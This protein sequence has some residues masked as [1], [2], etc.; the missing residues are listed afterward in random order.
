[1]QLGFALLS[2]F[3][4]NDHEE[5][6]FFSPALWMMA[7]ASL[8]FLSD[9]HLELSQINYRDALLLSTFTSTWLMIWQLVSLHRR[10]RLHQCTKP[11][12]R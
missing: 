3:L 4:F 7:V 2:L 9:R 6:E 8:L 1:M 11:W 12:L 10:C 5:V